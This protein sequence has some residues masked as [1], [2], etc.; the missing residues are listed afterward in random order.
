[1]SRHSAAFHLLVVLGMGMSATAQA[2][3]TRQPPS[4]LPATTV[5]GEA[6]RRVTVQNDQRTAVTLFIDAGRVDRAIGTVQPGAITSI[7]LPEWALRGQR[8]VKV[9]ARTDA[10]SKAIASYSLPVDENRELGVLVPPSEGLPS[11][12]SIFVTLPTGTAEHATLTVSNE[13]GQP[14]IVY[15][16]QGLMYVR[17]GEV[18]GHRQETLVIPS[19]LTKSKGAIRVFARTGAAGVATA[20]LRL[21]QGDHLAVIVM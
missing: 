14:V 5:T 9:V 12:D 20:A 19:L 16:E 21:K 17:L 2:Q 7:A 11:G 13:R 15:A 8:T 4:R 10:G 18:A 6:G 3:E 1:M